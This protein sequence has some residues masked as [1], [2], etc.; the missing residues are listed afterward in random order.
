MPIRIIIICGFILNL[1]LTLSAQQDPKQLYY[2]QQFKDI[3]IQEMARSG[4][5]AS[6]T[7]AQGILESGA[8]QSELAQKANNHFGIKCSTNWTGATYYKTDDDYDENGQLI[9]SCF[10]AY[11]AVE[12]SFHD[13][14]DFL[15]DPRKAYRYGPLFELGPTDYQGWAYGLKEAGY[16]TSD[17]YPSKLIDLI[18]RY[19]L[20]DYD[21]VFSTPPDT[22]QHAFPPLISAT[23]GVTHT[24]A[25]GYETAQDVALRTSIPL[26]RLLAY[27]EQLIA[28]FVLPRGEKVFLARKQK[29]YKGPRL[30]HEVKPKETMYDIAQKYGIDLC[31]LQGRNRMSEKVQPKTGE[32]IKLGGRRVRTAPLV[33]PTAD[34][35]VEEEAP[36]DPDYLPPIQVKPPTDDPTEE[37]EVPPSQALYHTVEI[38]DTLWNIARRYATTVEQLKELNNLENNNIR[39][40]MAIRVR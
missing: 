13:H 9:K 21:L 5:P 18:Q 16:A 39:R 14:S 28:G 6:I 12:K 10:R 32:L 7:L 33:Y 1:G 11:E 17:T 37:P 8:G 30:F 23:N 15:T 29:S 26:E 4:I 36:S 31:I 34:A 38:N 24:F 22:L 27:N 20:S 25:S 35:E 40:G 19:N 2:I 3:A